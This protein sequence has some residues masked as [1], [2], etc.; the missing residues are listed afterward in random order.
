MSRIGRLPIIIPKS[1]KIEY[2][3]SSVTVTG[4]LGTLKQEI[5]NSAITLDISGNTIHVLRK[6]EIKS[7][8]A[9]HGLYRALIANMVTGV[10]KGFTKALIFNG[11]GYK[12]QIQGGNLVLNVG[13]SHP[14]T[15]VPPA[16]VK[17][18][19]VGANELTV[20]GVDKTVVGQCAA[21]IKAIRRPEPYHG[22]GI[23]YKDETIL[24]K[25]GKAAGK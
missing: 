23:Q 11:V 18:G 16:G 9:A 24:R 2:D 15:V 5:A 13:Y 14:V 3:G 22:Y 21:N 10:D 7:T 1:V 6:N 25:E 4:P 12:A 19:V 17:L 8:K 20:T